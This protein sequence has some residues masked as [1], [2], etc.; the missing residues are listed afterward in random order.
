[1]ETDLQSLNER[2][3]ISGHVSFQPGPG[4][5]HAAI[6]NNAHATG[7]MTLAGG[8]VVEFA[9]RGSQPILWVSPNAMFVLGKPIRG[10][11][12]IC[13]PWFGPHPEDPASYP[14]HGFV[15]TMPWRVT[16]TRALPDGSTEVRMAVSDTPDTR[17]IWPHAF[18]LEITATF[19]E[20]L[21]VEWAAR[22]T[23]SAPFQYTGAMHPYYSISDI[24]GITIQGL[25][26]TSYLDKNDAYRRKVQAGS[27]KISGPTDAV[28]LDTTSELLVEDP[29][30]GRT[31]HIAKAGSH[32]SVVWNPDAGDAKSAD[33]G[34]GQ[35]HFFVCV[36]AANAG[37]EVITVAPGGE[38][39][40][41]MIIWQ[42]Q[43]GHR[44]A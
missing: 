6:I 8:H 32:T 39:H 28:F 44:E 41:A 9:R 3:A 22:N 33:I 10:G 29:G 19:G 27:L 20:K 18:E 16:G 37:G 26:G 43:E 12:P 5:L 24:R 25:D 34:E 15:R 13:W 17:A 4:G 38:H 42:E 35:H 2:F 21:R 7:T 14:L 31:L 30:F 1:M 23:G 40:L 36:E 11:V